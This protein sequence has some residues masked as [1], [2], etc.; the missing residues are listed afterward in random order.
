IDARTARVLTEHRSKQAEERLV[1]GPSWNGDD[2]VFPTALGSPIFPDTVSHLMPK[3]IA[4][5]NEGKGR[6]HRAVR[7]APSGPVYTTFGVCMRRRCYWP[8]FRRTW[9]LNG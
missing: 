4:A 8:A 6:L 9:W 7:A 5:H 2:R 1:A 3:L